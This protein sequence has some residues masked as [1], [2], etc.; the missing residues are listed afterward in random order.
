MDTQNPRNAN[1]QREDLA[2]RLSVAALHQWKESLRGAIAFPAAIALSTAATAMF[3]AS[4]IDRMFDMVDGTL[5]DV[6]KRLRDPDQ[7]ESRTEL[8]PS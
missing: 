7:R 5:I 2:Q 4:A 6:G 8:R 1:E 3:L